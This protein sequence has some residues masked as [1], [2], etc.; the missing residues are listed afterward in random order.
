MNALPSLDD[1]IL[2]RNLISFT[3]RDAAPD[4]SLEQQLL[5]RKRVLERGLRDPFNS[6]GLFICRYKRS[7]WMWERLED[8]PKYL[9]AAQATTGNILYKILKVGILKAFSDE[10]TK[11]P[12]NHDIRPLRISNAKGTH[13]DKIN[14]IYYPI[15]ELCPYLY[16][17]APMIYLK[18]NSDSERG[19]MNS[20]GNDRSCL[21]IYWV[22][23]NDNIHEGKWWIGNTYYMKLGVGHGFMKAC[24]P[25]AATP[26]HRTP[27]HNSLHWQIWTGHDSDH[28]SP[29]R[30]LADGPYVDEI[31]SDPTRPLE[32]KKLQYNCD[33]S[34][35]ADPNQD[36]KDDLENMKIAI[37]DSLDNYHLIAQKLWNRF[38]EKQRCTLWENDPN[39]QILLD[40][41]KICK[42]CFMISKNKVKCIHFDCPGACTQ[43]HEGYAG[44]QGM[45]RECIA[46][47][48]EQ[49]V[50]CP[51]CFEE[52]KS[53]YLRIFKCRHF[54]CMK[55]FITAFEKKKAIKKC[56]CCRK[57]IYDV[58]V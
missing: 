14:G 17:T 2:P 3:A 37:K 52:E 21:W 24:T 23:N 55:C 15:L 9:W 6:L 19:Y 56:P 35:K 13:A 43:C 25:S 42:C 22:Q 44:K 28:A 33:G 10:Y 53:K 1:Q 7:R 30:W 34:F 54:V 41:N 47:K 32:I 8:M 45:G 11:L 58:G 18:K 29:G 50:K 39:L 38:P 4:N 12:T 40:R 51:I 27:D 26:G 36:I 31:N 20:N 49:I 5:W 48:R 46:C 16:D 57:A